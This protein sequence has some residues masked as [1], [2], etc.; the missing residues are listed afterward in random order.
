MDPAFFIWIQTNFGATSLNKHHSE[1]CRVKT[2]CNMSFQKEAPCQ[3]WWQ[4]QTQKTSKFQIWYNWS[5][6][7]DLYPNPWSLQF[8]PR[9]G[10]IYWSGSAKTSWIRIWIHFLEIWIHNTEIKYIA[11]SDVESESEVEAE[12]LSEPFWYGSGSSWKELIPLPL[13]AST[14]MKA[15]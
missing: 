2:L 9:S 11:S 4:Q 7:V 13:P 1:D 5:S 10:S 3:A 8:F 12:V 6:V 14:S 15:V